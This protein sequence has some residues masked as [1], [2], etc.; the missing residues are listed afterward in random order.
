M[1]RDERYQTEFRRILVMKWLFIAILLL[2]VSLAQAKVWYVHKDSK[3]PGMGTSTSPFC[4]IQIGVDAAQPGDVIKIRESERVYNEMV[5]LTKSG[6]PGN[7]IVLE[8]DSG[9]RPVLTASAPGLEMGAITNIDQSYWTIRGLTFGGKG[10]ETPGFAIYGRT[11]NK[12]IEEFNIEQNTIRY[13]GGTLENTRGAAGI[14]FSSVRNSKIVD[15]KFSRNAHS[16]ILL[17]RTDGIIIEGNDISNG[18]C[19]LKLDGRVGGD[20]IKVSNGSINTTITENNIYEFNDDECPFPEFHQITAIYCDTGGNTG[21]IFRNRIWNFN[22]KLYAG[23]G[24]GIYLESRCMHWVV[25]DNLVRNVGGDGFKNGSGGAADNNK[26]FHNTMIGGKT[27]FNMVRGNNVAFMNNLLL[28][29]EVAAV[30][31]HD[32]AA[33]QRPHI[34]YNVY[35]K[36]QP[37]RI[38]M[39]IDG[40]VG[41]DAWREKC[42]C[43]FNSI[44]ADPFIM[45]KPGPESPA[46]GAGADGE[47]IGIR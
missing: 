41:L 24:H 25:E 28:D 26:W 3:C 27:G 22:N 20:G 30:K 44:V 15:N 10:V 34:D 14:K 12:E 33:S 42:N 35:W 11:K 46:I 17:G 4:K 38:A 39:W 8:A 31:V 23:G 29:N 43:D 5:N 32:D 47:D 37:S 18:R 36:F 19:G 40:V 7:P 13:W 2:Q 6:S 1:L 16:N 45:Y 9:H 21:H